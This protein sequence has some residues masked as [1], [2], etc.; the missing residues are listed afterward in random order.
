MWC[1]SRIQHTSQTVAS[2]RG[3]LFFVA[4]YQSTET[5]Y[6]VLAEEFTTRDGTFFIK[7]KV[8][9]DKNYV[10]LKIYHDCGDGMKVSFNLILQLLKSALVCSIAC[11][12]AFFQPGQRKFNFF[13]PT[14]Y[15]TDKENGE[16][17]FSLFVLSRFQPFE[18]GELN[19]E[20]KFRHNE[21][22]DEETSKRRRRKNV[23][24]FNK[25]RV[26][27]SA[28]YDNPDERIEPW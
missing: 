6:D 27:E 18:F 11:K 5:G 12:I 7:G 25:K 8:F 9:T 28:K 14:K 15:A 17:E 4:I 21:E 3:L 24:F 20:T 22:R 13:I 23:S 1:T 2:P 19:L 16:V 10:V 26:D